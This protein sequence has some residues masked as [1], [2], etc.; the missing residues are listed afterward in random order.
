MPLAL[1]E[2]ALAAMEF[3]A[4]EYFSKHRSVLQQFIVLQVTGTIGGPAS[5]ET[6]HD[7][8]AAF[9]DH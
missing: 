9:P 6:T 2:Y 4:A 8:L 3:V 1:V 5:P 7:N